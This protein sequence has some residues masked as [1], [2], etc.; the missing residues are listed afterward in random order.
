MLA[1]LSG[2]LL[3]K[4]VSAAVLVP[5]GSAGIWSRIRNLPY[6]ARLSVL[7]VGGIF[8]L[9]STVMLVHFL[10][11]FLASAT[12]GPESFRDPQWYFVGRDAGAL[13]MMALAWI[14]AD[15]PVALALSLGLTTFLVYSW[16]F[17]VNFVCASIVLGLILVSGTAPSVFVRRFAVTAFALSLPALVLGDQAGASSAV[18]WIVCL[19]GAVLAATLS[20]V[21][22][23][24]VVPQL[25]LRTSTL[26]AMTTLMVTALGLA[27]VA[28]GSIIVDSGWHFFQRERLTPELKE[29]WSVVRERTPKDTLVF[30]DQV[31]ES[32]DILGG[33]N[34]YAYSGQ[35]QVY[36]SS[37]VTSFI[38][39]ND[40][41]KLRE[42]LSINASVLDGSESPGKVPTRRRYNSF[43]AVVSASHAI[44]PK[45]RLIFENRQ[46]ALY[47]IM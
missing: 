30:T 34:T 46:Y 47:E 40:K 25:T 9:Y 15:L 18:I 24:T 10:P 13:L 7:G 28:R 6:L 35:R 3:S 45:W 32:E 19:G 2:S 11:V 36:L 33:W 39:R 31:D 44:P 26:V 1:G 42:I 8:G 16:V 43:H 22:I 29:I 12:P 23:T 41:E 20:A 37:Y 17:Q 27:G 4:I 14:I 38:L 21:G 5:L